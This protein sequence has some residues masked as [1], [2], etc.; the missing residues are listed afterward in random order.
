MTNLYNLTKPVFLPFR[1][2]TVTTVVR[3]AT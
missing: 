2:A 3:S 1:V